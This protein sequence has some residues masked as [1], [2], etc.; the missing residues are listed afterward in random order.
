MTDCRSSRCPHL[1]RSETTAKGKGFGK[2]AG[3]ELVGL[4]SSRF[5]FVE[6]T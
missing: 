5:F 1:L 4:D 6:M 3:K 2:P